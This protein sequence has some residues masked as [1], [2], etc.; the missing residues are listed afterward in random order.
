MTLHPT[1]SLLKFLIYDEN[2]I[3]FFISVQCMSPR[4]NLDS[5]NPSLAS[6][7]PSPQNGGGGG[8]GT[9]ACGLVVGGDP[10]PTSGEKTKH[11]TT[12]QMNVVFCRPMKLNLYFLS[13]KR[14]P[15]PYL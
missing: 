13:N 1:R 4:R 3:F 6:E 11:S 12:H 8:R 14:H 7:S 5:P 10:I 2:S 15:S 9:L